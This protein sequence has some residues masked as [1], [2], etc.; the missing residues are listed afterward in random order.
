MDVIEDNVVFGMNAFFT[1]KPCLNLIIEKYYLPYLNIL[2]YYKNALIIYS[3][4][5]TISVNFIFLVFF[6]V[7]KNEAFL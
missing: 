5:L 3:D 2:S 1:N 7:L 4:L 6:Y